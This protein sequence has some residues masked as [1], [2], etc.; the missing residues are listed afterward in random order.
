MC[1]ERAVQSSANRVS[2]KHLLCASSFPYELHT[3][4]RAQGRLPLLRAP[5]C[6]IP[7]SLCAVKLPRSQT[8]PL[9]FIV[10][11]TS[12]CSGNMRSFF[13]C[14]LSL[15]RMTSS[16]LRGC[17]SCHW[18]AYRQHCLPTR[19]CRDWVMS[20]PFLQIPALSLLQS[21]FW[22]YRFLENETVDALMCTD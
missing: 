8:W 7:S 5:E 3:W 15:W 12:C 10:N 2:I 11:C 14:W 1:N 16:K 6:S 18:P 13:F 22:V 19:R 17:E 4:S 20:G 9:G 21:E